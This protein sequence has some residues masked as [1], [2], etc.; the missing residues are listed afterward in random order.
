MGLHASQVGLDS[1][2]LGAR[3]ERQPE[4]EPTVR[5]GNN[6]A[7]RR[8]RAFRSCL[9]LATMV[10][11]EKHMQSASVPG[12]P[13]LVMQGIGARAQSFHPNCNMACLSVAC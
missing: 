11:H 2:G 1:R 5:A 7:A 6:A 13:P 4:Q 12:Q 10:V 8:N 3:V 9:A